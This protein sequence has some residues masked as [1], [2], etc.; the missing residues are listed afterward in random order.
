MNMT[1]SVS[2][3]DKRGDAAKVIKIDKKVRQR[4]K[5]K[6]KWVVAVH[7]A[8]RIAMFRIVEAVALFIVVSLICVIIGSTVIPL[9]AYEMSA[10][11]GLTQSTNI[12][13]AFASWILPMLF[14]TLLITAATFCVLKKFI[15]W[16][17]NKINNAINKSK[18][19]EMTEKETT[20]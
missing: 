8:C 9:F 19:A 4:E 14:Y 11:F 18:K 12:Y 5:P 3:K 17:H 1:K 2:K 7:N 20:V 16:L 15:K 10:G 6:H 13:I